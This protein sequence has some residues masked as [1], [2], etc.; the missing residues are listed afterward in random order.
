LGTDAK[1][2]TLRH[3]P[4]KVKKTETGKKTLAGNAHILRAERESVQKVSMGNQNDFR[5]RLL[6]REARRSRQGD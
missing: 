1:A 5:Q 3:N 2:A 6:R 4:E